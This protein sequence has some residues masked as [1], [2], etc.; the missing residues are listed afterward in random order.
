MKVSELKVMFRQLIERYFTGA[1]VTYTKQSFRTKPKA[2][3]VTLST[4]SVNRPLNPPTKIIDGHPVSFYPAS[5]PIQI[6]LFTHGRQMEVAAGYTPVVEN[7]AEDDLIG[8]ADFLNSDYVIQWCHERDIAIVVPN[9]V[10]DLTGLINDTNYEFRAMLEI[11]VYFTMT[12]IGYTG[13]LA[14]ESV[15]HSTVAPNGDQIDY[16]GEDIQADDVTGL[17]PEIAVTPSGGGNQELLE[18]EGGYFS[19]VEI[20]KRLVREENANERKS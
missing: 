11:M 20:N 18:E 14:P 7:T 6:D 2:P 9:T 10:Q 4:G 5:M 16:E 3:L 19:N 17:K 15:K 12:A 13:T 8:F 1:T